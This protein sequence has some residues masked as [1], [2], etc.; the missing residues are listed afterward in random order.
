[1]LVPPRED[2]ELYTFLLTA[3]RIGELRVSLE[4]LKGDLCVVTRTLKT[5]AEQQA[6]EF[7][8]SG[9]VLIS[10]PL[11]VHAYQTDTS[12]VP[13]RGNQTMLPPP[14]DAVAKEEARDRPDGKHGDDQRAQGRDK[15]F[16]LSH[17]ATMDEHYR[18]RDSSKTAS[19]E[20]YG[21]QRAPH[22][23]T[24]DAMPAPVIAAYPASIPPQ[25]LHRSSRN[26]PAFIVFYRIVALVLFVAISISVALSSAHWLSAA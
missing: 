9:S 2:S 7:L 12:Q 18:G 3:Q 19:R 21:E 24:R 16:D 6:S 4:V 17:S 23:D 8:K 20:N 13:G 10:I 26:W 22:E 1:V 11:Y 5:L 15:S 14:V 25:S